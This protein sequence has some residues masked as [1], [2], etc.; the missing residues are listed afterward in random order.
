MWLDKAVIDSLQGGR[1]ANNDCFQGC[2]YCVKIVLISLVRFSWISIPGLCWA[3]LHSGKTGWSGYFHSNKSDGYHQHTFLVQSETDNWANHWYM[4]KTVEA[5][6]LFL[7]EYH[8]WAGVLHNFWMGTHWQD[9]SEYDYVKKGEK[10]LWV[11]PDIP[12]RCNLGNRISWS[13][14]S[15]ALLR[16]RKATVLTSLISI[17]QTQ[18]LVTS[19]RLLL[20]NGAH[21]IQIYWCLDKILRSDKLAKSWLKITLSNILPVIEIHWHW[22][23]IWLSMSLLS[24]LTWIEELNPCGLT[25]VRKYTIS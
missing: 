22:M 18:L 10:H 8:T 6:I 17:L 19:I 7:G 5:L 21:A 11:T 14:L 1:G 25:I 15:N 2:W 3:S 23:I 20:L 13:T 4:A 9:M 16:S 12:Q 24:P